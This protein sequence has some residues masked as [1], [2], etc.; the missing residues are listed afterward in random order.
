MKIVRYVAIA[1]M[2]FGSLYAKDIPVGSLEVGG[3]ASL[4]ANYSDVK[5]GN[6]TDISLGASGYYYYTSDLAFGVSLG[7]GYTKYDLED[8]TGQTNT[9][10]SFSLAPSV[11]YLISKQE[12]MNTFLEA[13]LGYV[14]L[15]QKVEYVDVTYRDTDTGTYYRLGTG[16]DYFIN[17][18]IA[19]TPSL[20]YTNWFT[21]DIADDNN[22]DISLH[23]GLKVFLF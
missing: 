7:Y 20:N 15:K 5:Y 22:Y 10:N 2:L 3:S 18:N 23:V 9:T 14:Y 1:S 13:S 19:I 12:H 6:E 16:I 21:G 4:G 8:Y 11:K 17:D